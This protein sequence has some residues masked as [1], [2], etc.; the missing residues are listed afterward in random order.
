MTTH[1][2]G[3]ITIELDSYYMHVNLWRW[4]VWRW[5]DWPWWKWV[6]VWNPR[7]GNW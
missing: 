5:R 6:R 3:P 1:R 4:R 7:E 2:V